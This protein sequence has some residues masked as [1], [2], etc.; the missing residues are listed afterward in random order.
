M[1]LIHVHS[2]FHFIKLSERSSKGYS[3]TELLIVIA[4]FVFLSGFITLSLIH[5]QQHASLNGTIDQLTADMKQQQL[6]SMIN[7][8]E[9]RGTTDTYGIYFQSTA[10]TLFHGATYSSGDP[11]NFVVNLDTGLQFSAINLPAS[12]IIFAKGSGEVAGFTNG[13]NTVRLQNTTS[14]D[15]KTITVNQYGAIT[16]VN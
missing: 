4:I 7:D 13:E 16:T 12:S 5:T 8:T 15:T 2:F 14:G 11:T 9:G 10:Y 3:I 6:K 1:N